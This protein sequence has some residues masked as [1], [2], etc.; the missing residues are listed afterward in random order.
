MVMN[1]G[2]LFLCKYLAS[3]SETLCMTEICQNMLIPVW[4][5]R[6]AWCHTQTKRRGVK[7]ASLTLCRILFFSLGVG[8]SLSLF[9]PPV[10]HHSHW[11]AALLALPPLLL[12]SLLNLLCDGG[13]TSYGLN[14]LTVS[15]SLSL[16]DGPPKANAGGSVYPSTHLS[17]NTK[18]TV[19]QPLHLSAQVSGTCLLGKDNEEHTQ[20]KDNTH[21]ATSYF[22]SLRTLPYVGSLISDLLL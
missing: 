16:S 3:G 7:I 10:S 15:L 1:S 5:P 22:V 9:F 14:F 21:P 12:V 2:W 6:F 17:L 20:L 13:K 8:C 4:S 18:Q 19:T 11:I